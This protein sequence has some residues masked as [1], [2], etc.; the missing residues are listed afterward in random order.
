MLSSKLTN[1]P[2]ARC[3]TG[4][5]EEITSPLK[6]RLSQPLCKTKICRLQTIECPPK[7][8]ALHVKVILLLVKVHFYTEIISLQWLNQ[9]IYSL[10]FNFRCRVHSSCNST[11][12]QTFRPL[13]YV[14]P[15]I[16]LTTHLSCTPVMH[17]AP[18]PNI[19]F[20]LQVSAYQ[21]A[22]LATSCWRQDSQGVWLVF[23]NQLFVNVC[24]NH[25]QVVFYYH[26]YLFHSHSWKCVIWVSLFIK[27]QK[28]INKLQAFKHA[29]VREGIHLSQICLKISKYFLYKYEGK[30]PNTHRVTKKVSSKPF[31]CN[32]KWNPETKWD[33][34]PLVAFS[35]PPN[36]INCLLQ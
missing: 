20:T 28:Q 26:L 3:A 13:I 10:S 2:C 16:Q 17:Q 33:S 23:C 4:P 29:W 7:I 36:L 34:I 15:A 32:R 25:D 11:A 35:L 5:I 6:P 22:H 21:G 30:S 19:S 12:F 14:P 18:G 24:T 8:R 9:N 1:S 31:L 27:N